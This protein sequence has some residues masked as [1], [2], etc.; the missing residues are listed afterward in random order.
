MYSD[1]FFNHINLKGD[2]LDYKIIDNYRT[3]FYRPDGT[4]VDE[5]NTIWVNDVN[6]ISEICN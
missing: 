5:N 6:Q 4:Y 3:N 2:K 1:A